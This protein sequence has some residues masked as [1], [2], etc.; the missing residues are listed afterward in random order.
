[1]VTRNAHQPRHSEKLLTGIHVWRIP[2]SVWCVLNVGNPEGQ[3]LLTE[4]ISNLRH[5]HVEFAHAAHHDLMHVS[6]CCRL[7]VCTDW[8]CAI[9]TT[10]EGHKHSYL[11]CVVRLLTVQ[12]E[13]VETIMLCLKACETIHKIVVKMMPVNSLWGQKSSLLLHVCHLWFLLNGFLWTT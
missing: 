12:M 10:C 8:P 4:S 7:H 5:S 13:A 11:N 2:G 9:C 3:K 6:C 1:M